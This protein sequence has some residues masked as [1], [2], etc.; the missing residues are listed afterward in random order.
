MINS[1]VLLL[2]IVSADGPQQWSQFRGPSG[3]GHWTSRDSNSTIPVRWDEKTNVAWKVRLNG[4]GHSSPV[5]W[6]KRL[7]AT[8]ALNGGKQLDVICVHLDSGKILYQR[9]V[10]D[11]VDTQRIH[12]TS[13]H[14]SPTP[15]VEEG[16][17]YVHF[18]SY[19]TAC[20]DSMSGKTLWTRTDLVVNHRHGPASSPI[21]A[22]KVVIL[23]FDGLDKQFMVALDKTSGETA[24]FKKRDIAYNTEV[25]ERKKAFCTPLLITHEDTEQLVTTAARAAIAYNAVDG[26]ELWRVRF[27]GDS[28][29]AKPVYGGGMLFLTTS[30]VDAK[31]LAI[32]PSGRGDITETGVD[33]LLDKGIPQRPS[34]LFIDGLLYCMHDQ[35][36]LTC[37]DPKTGDAIW[38]ERLGG[39]FAASPIFAGGNIYIPSQDGETFVVK[40]GRAF[41]L[42]NKNELEEGCMSSPAAND[43]SLFLRTDSHLYRISK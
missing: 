33:W 1:I 32:N 36:V 43:D 19:G 31:M 27:I 28:A 41:Q 17:V 34:P 29:T 40:P 38:K 35:G 6:G 5:I 26:S 23:Q 16:R 42:I 24:W 7:W 21:V 13:S 25:G 30:C 2:A 37:R 4:K 11:G 8:T 3:D 22:G 10:F 18:G 12:T 14:A 9:T 20:L 15:V 39:N